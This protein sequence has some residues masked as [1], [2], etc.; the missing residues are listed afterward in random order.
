M[1]SNT[2]ATVSILA[3]SRRGAHLISDGSKA[4]W[5]MNRQ[6][7][8]DNTL[9]AGAREALATSEMTHDEAVKL[10][11]AING[12]RE[13]AEEL[14]EQRREAARVENDRE[15]T[16]NIARENW[17]GEHGNAWQVR[18]NNTF[19]NRF[20]KIC[21]ACEFLPKS[22]VIVIPQPDGSVNVTLAN[23]L[24]KAKPSMVYTEVNNQ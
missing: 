2:P 11:A 8:D 14:R 17:R 3:T 24:L 15:V 7:R 18:T 9:T 10:A 19:R 6:V 16:I 13:A 5:V 12:N 21:T 4:V 23:W 1:N 20:G 22:R